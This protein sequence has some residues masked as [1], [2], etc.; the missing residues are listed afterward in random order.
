M[1]LTDQP[2]DYAALYA[3][4]DAPIAA[5]DCGARCA[6]HNKSGAPFC[7]DT[8][9]AVPTVYEDE[10]AYLQAQTDLWHLWQGRSLAETRRVQ[11]E[12]PPG[13]LLLECKGHRLC[14]RDFRS[15]ACRAFP[16]FPYITVDDRFLGLTVY[17][18][19]RSQCWVISNLA[20]A[21]ERFR[22]ECIA[23][24]E[25]LFDHLPAE[26][27]GYRALSI[28]MRRVY[29]RWKRPI[30]LL[31]RNGG[32]YKIAPHSARLRRVDPASFEKFAPYD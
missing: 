27:D 32:F 29:S 25:T 10:W 1:S 22:Q 6:A 5:F 21:S 16:F 19:F 24:F 12:T 26:H 9:H 20:V 30:P 23:A 31:H 2:V 4:F 28:S 3:A 15:L 8:R 14:Q 11:E 17:W 13:M 7:C 18:Q